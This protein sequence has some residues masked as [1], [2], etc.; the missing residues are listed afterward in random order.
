[1]NFQRFP[2]CIVQTVN[3]TYVQFWGCHPSVLTAVL[4]QEIGPYLS[5]RPSLPW[6]LHKWN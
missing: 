6:G 1:M 4:R 5:A 3:N 2:T